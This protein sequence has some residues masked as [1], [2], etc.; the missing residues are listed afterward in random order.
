MS[1]ES[2]SGF[3]N[4]DA[5]EKSSAPKAT[6]ESL[7]MRT[8]L[9]EL[10][11]EG[12]T[13]ERSNRSGIVPTEYKVLVLPDDV[14]ERTAGGILVPPWA[15]DQ[16][17]GACQTGVVIDM[18][19]EAFCFLEDKSVRVPRIGERVAYTKYAGMTVRGADKAMYKLMND[20]DI[21]AVLDFPFDPKDYQF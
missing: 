13:V 7:D 6:F 19:P 15:R 10:V 5:A 8:G 16:R 18:S 14:P 21:A 9:Y 3:A 17:Q 11:V 4:S 1:D 2:V 12:E 20:K